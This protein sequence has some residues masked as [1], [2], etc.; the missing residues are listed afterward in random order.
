MTA[1]RRLTMFSHTPVEIPGPKLAKGEVESRSKE[2]R[3]A[4]RRLHHAM[5]SMRNGHLCS[6]NREW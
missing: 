2:D 5:F 4:D 6:C 1:A 3:I